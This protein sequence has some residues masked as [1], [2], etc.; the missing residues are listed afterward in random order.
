MTIHE[1]T[2]KDWDDFFSPEH[3]P[4]TAFDPLDQDDEWLCVVSQHGS[5]PFWETTQRLDEQAQEQ[6]SAPDGFIFDR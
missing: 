3:A 2:Q 1:A 6:T 5:V 4:K